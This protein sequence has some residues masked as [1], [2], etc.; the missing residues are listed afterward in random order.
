MT[1]YYKCPACGKKKLI[2]TPLRIECLSCRYINVR[3]E[4]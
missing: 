3:K 2:H 1:K 4:Q